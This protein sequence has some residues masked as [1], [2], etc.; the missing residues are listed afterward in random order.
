MGKVIYLFG[1]DISTDAIYP[2]RYMATV[3]PSE[4]PQFC[5]ADYTDLNKKLNSKEY[6]AG[7]VIIGGNNFGC[8]SSREQAASTILGHGLIVIAKDF[9][10]I[11][12]QN[13]INLGLNLI[14]CPDIVA[15]LDDEIEVTGDKVIN[16]TKNLEFYTIPLPAA[17]LSIVEAGGLVAYTRKK[18]IQKYSK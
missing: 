8:G 13:A 18:V 2:G 5:F 4:T 3:L 11:F 14:T 17:R 16:K 12:L 15:D 6:P 10:R 1:N 7:S 9:A